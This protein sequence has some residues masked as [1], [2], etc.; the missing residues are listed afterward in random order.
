MGRGDIFEAGAA[1]RALAHRS[2][3]NL[4]IFAAAA[5]PSMA[6]TLPASTTR[7]VLESVTEKAKV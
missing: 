7:E 4:A 6:V 3:S 2:T 5:P 1:W